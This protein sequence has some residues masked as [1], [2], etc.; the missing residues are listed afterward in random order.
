MNVLITPGKLSGTVQI[1]PSKSE[2]HRAIIASSL[3]K[4]KSVIS[5]VSFSDDVL[6]TIGA[7]EKIGVKFSKSAQQL[8]VNG[9][10]R[11]FLSDD[12]FIDCNESGSTLRF[13][14]P[15][16]SLSK[17]K[18]VFTGKPGLFRR[19]MSIYENMFKQMNL[20][21][22]QSEKSIIMSGSLIPGVYE[23]PG[24]VSSQ[25][26]SGLLFALPLLKGD[27]I[28]KITTLLE[29]EDYVTMT[30]RMLKLYGITID[31]F[32]NEFHI[33][34]NQIYTP[35]HFAV[36]GDYTQMAVY[37]VAGFL[38]GDITVKNINPDASQPDRRI[39]DFG[40]QMGGLFDSIENGFAFKKSTTKGITIDIGQ[41][42]DIGPILALLGALSEGTTVIDN[43]TRL[44]YK[45][46]NRLLS[47][48]ETLKAMGVD[49]TMTESSLTIQGKSILEGGTFDSFGDH[50]IV[51]MAAISACRSH[52]PVLI[53]N[54]DAVNKSYPDFFADFAKIGGNFTVIEG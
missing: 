37:A 16:L 18:V 12:N 32:G 1:P 26:I 31:V 9:V 49:V 35:A 2:T 10:G 40:K 19:P 36:E 27:S 15:L 24:N 42:P 50:R 46:S 21:F 22:L 38:N 7:M 23:L 44:Q 20:S 43:A 52:K 51:M 30:V 41:S 53:K 11:V 13:L 17:Q 3:A 48:Y 5:N 6:A 8:T 28:V 4:G 54:A 33:K 39:L 34:G 47:T 29:S 14:I 45:E 25:F